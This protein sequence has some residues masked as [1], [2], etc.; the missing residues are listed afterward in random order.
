M[1]RTPRRSTPSPLRLVS[2]QPTPG[3]HAAPFEVQTPTR[4]DLDTGGGLTIT[5]RPRPT[6]VDLPADVEEAITQA[7]ADA[8]VIDARRR[9]E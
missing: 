8:L 4:A 5:R 7:L 3:P 1:P 2:S 6:A 9:D